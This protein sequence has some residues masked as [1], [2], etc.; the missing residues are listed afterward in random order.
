LFLLGHEVTHIVH[1]HVDYLAANRNQ[2]FTIELGMFSGGDEEKIERQSIEIDADRQSII[3]RIDSLRTTF[4]QPAPPN[5]PWNPNAKRSIDILFDWALS[6]N[7]VFRLFGDLRFTSID[8]SKSAYPPLALRRSMC[9][10]AAHGMAKQIW[11]PEIGGLALKSVLVARVE[12]EKAFGIMLG[13]KLDLGTRPEMPPQGYVNHG[14][15]LEDH[16][17]SELAERLKPFIFGN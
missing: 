13:E 4:D 12:A 16:L 14:K 1:G 3:S 8:P 5:V 17:N 15:I 9:E 10:A 6:I 2:R 7:I 11:G